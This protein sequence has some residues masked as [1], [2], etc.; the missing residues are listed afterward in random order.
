M[1]YFHNPDRYYVNWLCLSHTNLNLTKVN[2][3]GLVY[4]WQGTDNN[5]KPL[6][7]TGHQGSTFLAKFPSKVLKFLR[8][9]SR[10]SFD[11]WSMDSPS[12]FWPLW[13]YDFRFSYVITSQSAGCPQGTYIWGR[14]SSDDKGGLI[15][16]MCVP[17]SFTF[18]PI[19]RFLIRSTVEILL[20]HGFRPSRTI[21]LAFGFDEETGGHFV[22]VCF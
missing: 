13:W 11:C 14:G 5:L 15:S 17:F 20:K 16:I 9:R 6:L 2:T 1:I 21:V 12:L 19:I 4:H 10:R 22:C 8:C 7:L 18:Q 3:Y